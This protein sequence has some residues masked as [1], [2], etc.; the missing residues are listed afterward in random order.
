MGIG[1]KGCRSFGHTDEISPN[2]NAAGEVG[3]GSIGECLIGHGW[4]R[5]SQHMGSGQVR[6]STAAHLVCKQSRV[7]HCPLADIYDMYLGSTHT[8]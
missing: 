7:D 2:S 6:E 4:I 8:Q 3:T 1:I 5:H